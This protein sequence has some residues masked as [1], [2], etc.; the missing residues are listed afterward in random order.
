MPHLFVN[1]I[2]PALL[3]QSMLLSRITARLRQEL[4]ISVHPHFWVAAINDGV[5]KVL[6]DDPHC[7]PH[8]IFQQSILLRCCNATFATQLPMR[9]VKVRVSIMQP[10]EPVDNIRRMIV[11]EDV[12][13]RIESTAM[14]IRDTDLSNALMRLAKKLK[15]N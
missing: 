8:I 6:S 9:L 1:L 3:A 11:C 2:D 14:C 7:V 5:L 15:R 4:P 13:K 12:P 10:V